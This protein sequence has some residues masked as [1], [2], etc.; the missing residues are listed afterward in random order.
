MITFPFCRPGTA[1]PYFFRMF[2]KLKFVTVIVSTSP[3]KQTYFLAGN[4]SAFIIPRRKRSRQSLFSHNRRLPLDILYSLTEILLRTC[5][6]PWHPDRTSLPEQLRN[7]THRRHPACRPSSQVRDDL[8]TGSRRL[9][10]PVH[11]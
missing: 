3:S 11:R 2:R 9:H 6:H 8:R 4:H 1:E 7:R 5:T 10:F